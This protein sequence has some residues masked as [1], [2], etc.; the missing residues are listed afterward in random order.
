MA[1]P[2]MFIKMFAFGQFSGLNDQQQAYDVVV[3]GFTLVVPVSKNEFD[4][5]PPMEQHGVVAGNMKTFDSNGRVYI[6]QP[7]WQS[8]TD[9]KEWP[10]DGV[11]TRFQGT[12]T[13]EKNIWGEEPNKKFYLRLHKGGFNYQSQV[14]PEIFER[15]NTGDQQVY[16]RLI[17]AGQTNQQYHTVRSIWRVEPIGLF[18]AKNGHKEQ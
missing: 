9:E 15:F 6:D 2:S 8:I 5:P 13:V 14:E 12:V 1:L 4:N 16:G 7:R 10:T 18:R 11:L 17:P 3:D